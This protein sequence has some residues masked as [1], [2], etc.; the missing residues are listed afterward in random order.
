MAYTVIVIISVFVQA[1]WS[2]CPQLV[3][4][5]LEQHFTGGC[6]IIITVKAMKR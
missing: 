5:E 2:S 1:K 4:A 6:S 3:Q